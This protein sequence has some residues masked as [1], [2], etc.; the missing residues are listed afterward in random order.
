M[1]PE[2]GEIPEFALLTSGAHF[3]CGVLQALL[4]RGYRPRLLVLPTYPPPAKPTATAIEVDNGPASSICSIGENIETAYAPRVR[5]REAAASIARRGI[6]FLLVACWPY[7]I[8]REFA[9]SASGAALNLHPSLLPK[10]R[11]PDPLPQQL[12]AGD[13]RFGVTLHLLDQR[14]DCGDIIAQAELT[15]TCGDLNLRELESRCAELGA[16]LF[17]DALSAWPHWNP[18]P[19]QAS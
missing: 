11:G 8:D 16:L 17:I 15:E 9:A 19:Q 12:A 5:Q 7:L 6:E 1:N 4:R 14:F 13:G 10:Y 2:A 3:S 18:Q